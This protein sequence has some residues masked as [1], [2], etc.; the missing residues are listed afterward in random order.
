MIPVE[1]R[2]W[3][4]VQ[5]SQ[6]YD[7]S[8]KPISKNAQTILRQEPNLREPDGA[9]YW[10]RLTHMMHDPNPKTQSSN[11]DQWFDQTRLDVHI[12]LT[13]TEN[14]NKSEQ[15]NVTVAY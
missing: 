9:A 10:P 6:K 1:E 8:V 7:H 11:F 12:V 15:N 3:L 4:P 2:L 14:L 13:N 5:T